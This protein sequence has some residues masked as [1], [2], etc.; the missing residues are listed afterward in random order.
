MEEEIILNLRLDKEGSEQSLNQLTQS[1]AE[2]RDALVALQELHKQ[3]A[4][5]EGNTSK[6]ALD[7]A[8]SIDLQKQK[9]S[10]TN[11]IR[12][13]LVKVINQEINST[14]RLKAENNLLI[15]QRDALNL[16][17]EEGRKKLVE[18]NAAINHNTERLRSNVSAQEK[19]RM[20]IG[21]Y[22]SALSGLSSTLG[23]MLPG[24]NGLIAGLNGVDKAL[25]TLVANPIGATLAAI[26]LSL[27]ALYK[28][29]TSTSTG[30]DWLEDQMAVLS[31][32]FN[33]LIDRAGKLARA[34]IAV[35]SKDFQEAA[36]L[37]KEAFTGI[38]DEIARETRLVKELNAAM[39]DLED[40]NILY[41]ISSAEVANQIKRLELQAKNRT[42]TEKQRI[43]LIDQALALEKKQT[44]EQLALGERALLIAAQQAAMRLNIERQKGE[45]VIEFGKRVV[46]ATMEDGAAQIDAERDKVVELLKQQQ[47]YIGDSI[48]LQERLQN[49]RDKLEDEAKKKR[50]KAEEDEAKKKRE[51]AEK[52]AKDRA[53]AEKKFQEAL[54]ANNKVYN[55][56]RLEENQRYLRELINSNKSKEEIEKEHQEALSAIQ[57]Q[58][59]EARRKIEVAHKAS[60]IDTDNAITQIKIE[61]Q[62]KVNK[63]K[64][65]AAQLEIMRQ[66]EE[67]QMANQ[68][69][70]TI[71]RLAKEHTVFAKV[72]AIAEGTIN[73]YLGATKAIAQGGFAGI[74]LAAATIAAGL[75]NVAKI[76]GVDVAFGG[77]GDFITKGPT[78]L[79]VGDNPGGIERV[80][81]EPISGKGKTKIFNPTK[82]SGLN[83]G[84]AMAGGGTLTVQAAQQQR[85]MQQLIDSQQIQPV[86]ILQDFEYAKQAK[87]TPISRAQII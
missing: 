47:K 66:Q 37:A 14:G 53:E 69:F 75:A 34:I 33:V 29:F 40:A 62:K 21:N 39:R 60:T 17:T 13:D 2:Q 9:I 16:N 55:Q 72:A 61:N 85:Q 42:L 18:L 6:A 28:G 79:L 51:K 82:V 22:A 27:A 25:W 71:D 70:G 78:L 8:K 65:E 41:S 43:A 58:E 11:A 54:D 7:L 36:K 23:N 56:K 49:E 64:D 63:A 50:E 24:F 44:E 84:I 15:K 86:L 10:Q 67:V 68:V 12:N 83:G 57:I 87:D 48:A 26:V 77:G 73:T 32:T 74:A 1:L 3:V 35:F 19:Q 31:T 38:G 45:S 20:N 59:L 80:T 52:E 30:A 4:A 76:A 5:A 81:V 46:A